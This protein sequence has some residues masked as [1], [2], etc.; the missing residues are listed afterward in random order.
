MK[1]VIIAVGAIFFILMVVKDYHE[2]TAER[3]MLA[4]QKSRLDLLRVTLASENVRPT[5]VDALLQEQ[6]Y[7]ERRAP[8]NKRET[9]EE[10]LHITKEK[11]ISLIRESHAENTWY[12]VAMIG[13]RFID[14]YQGKDV[15]LEAEKNELRFMSKKDLMY[16]FGA[17]INLR[18]HW[19]AAVDWEMYQL[20]GK[21]REPEILRKI[22]EVSSEEKKVEIEKRLEE[23]TSAGIQDF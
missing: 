7:L 12:H 17:S 21:P 5:G 6:D 19:D 15:V 18:R 13:F 22:Q 4:D 10:L 16:R 9:D 8:Q 11:Y 20:R 23:L 2:R 3:E 14:A 1:K